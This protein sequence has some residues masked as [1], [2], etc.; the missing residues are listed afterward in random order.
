MNRLT[1]NGFVH[2]P[3]LVDERQLAVLGAAVEK[4]RTKERR[5]GLRNLLSGCPEVREFA[6]SPT[7]MSIVRDVL[8]DSATLLPVRAI[9]FDKTPDA[10]WYVTWH[11]DLSIP[12]QERPADASTDL[13]GYGPWSEKD[14]VVHV[15]PPRAVLE[16]M[17]SLRIHLDPCPESNGAI[18]FVAGSHRSGILDQ[19]T[20]GALRDRK[21]WSTVPASPGDVI[22]MR[23][24]VLHSSSQSESPEHR[25]VLHIEYAGCELPPP[26]RFRQA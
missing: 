1:V 18:R 17:V 21:E 4:V 5:A 23:P 6:L 14:G 25:R 2:L 26:L 24:L 22:V 11:Q 19:D 13:K 9:L 7:L 12:V 20:I 16:A 8:G 10:N 3:S 15:Q